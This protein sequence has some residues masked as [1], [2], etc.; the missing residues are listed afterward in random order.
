MSIYN[1]RIPIAFS[2]LNCGKNSVDILDEVCCREGEQFLC[3]A[4]EDFLIAFCFLK[5]L[6]SWL[7]L[8]L[9]SNLARGLSACILYVPSGMK[10]ASKAQFNIVLVRKGYFQILLI[11][12]NDKRE[13]LSRKIQ[14]LDFYSKMWIFLASG[15]Y[16]FCFFIFSSRCHNLSWILC[17]SV[18]LFH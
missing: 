6:T 14:E 10:R 3:L 1:S 13:F 7:I 12:W 16:E 15:V 18:R 9:Q 2:S 5:A 11:D 8:L 4:D 17:L